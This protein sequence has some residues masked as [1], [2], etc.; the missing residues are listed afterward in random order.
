MPSARTLTIN[1]RRRGRRSSLIVSP[2]GSTWVLLDAGTAERYRRLANEVLIVRSRVHHLP[3]QGDRAS[4]KPH[5]SSDLVPGNR[6]IRRH[7][8]A[9]ESAVKDTI[10]STAGGGRRFGPPE[11]AAALEERYLLLFESTG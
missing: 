4:S 9:K 3:Q 1:V 2:W 11:S 8:A 10:S 7:N 6:Y 5:R